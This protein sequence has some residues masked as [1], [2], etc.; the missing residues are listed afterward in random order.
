VNKIRWST[1]CLVCG[2]DMRWSG[3]PMA[4][5][6]RMRQ[7]ENGICDPCQR[8]RYAA[9]LEYERAVS[10]VRMLSDFGAVLGN[11]THGMTRN[12]QILYQAT[13]RLRAADAECVR[14]GMWPAAALAP[15]KLYREER[16]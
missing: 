11:R 6:E 8:A 1:D 14:L 15:A 3:P 13:H 9:A 2:K 10:E 12:N 7:I 5:S 16:A 4:R